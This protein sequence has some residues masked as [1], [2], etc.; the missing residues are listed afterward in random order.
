MLSAEEVCSAALE[1]IAPNGSIP[2]NAIPA[3]NTWVEQTQA[4]FT[5]L[6]G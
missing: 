3:Y 1:A 6:L 2:I 5:Y 4:F